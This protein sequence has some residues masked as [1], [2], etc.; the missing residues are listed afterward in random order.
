MGLRPARCYKWDSPAYTRVAKNPQDSFITGIPGSKIVR[1]EMGNLKGNFDTEISI[2]AK[3]KIQIR[4][5]ALESIRI[6][7]N[8]FLEEKVGLNEFKLKIRVIP[9]HVLRENIMA[10]GAGADRVQ[11]GMRDSF[12]KPIGTA[13][14]VK[15]GQPIVSVYIN[16]DNGEERMRYVKEALKKG[17]KKLPG[18]LEI[19]VKKKEKWKNGKMEEG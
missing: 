19:V 7:I 14:R 1:Y 9:H 16:K 18:E 17:V 10:T 4:H 8:K 12:G 3:E 15:K 11:S 13:A 5:N 2:V 6:I